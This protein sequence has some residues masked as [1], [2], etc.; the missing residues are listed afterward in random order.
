[1]SVTISELGKRYVINYDLLWK[2]VSSNVIFVQFVENE[3]KTGIVI[4]AL[5]FVWNLKATYDITYGP[6]VTK[7]GSI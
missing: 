4:K 5:N 1:M 3:L 2:M 6:N 7:Y